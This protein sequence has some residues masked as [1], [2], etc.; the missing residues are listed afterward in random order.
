MQILA[1]DLG[2]DMVPALAL[3]A[4]APYTSFGNALFGTTPIGY[5]AWLVVLPFAATMLVLEEARKAVVRRRDTDA[6]ARPNAGSGSIKE[7][8]AT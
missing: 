8:A 4:E 3:G 1:V 5:K 7:S 6:L 2:T